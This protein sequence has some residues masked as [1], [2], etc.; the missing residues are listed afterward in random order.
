[1]GM[2]SSGSKYYGSGV[3]LSL[4]D[5]FPTQTY[6]KQKAIFEAVVNN[7]D[8]IDAILN[9]STDNYYSIPLET[10]YKTGEYLG[11]PRAYL[12]KTAFG[13][14]GYLS[15]ELI[16]YLYNELGVAAPDNAAFDFYPDIPV[17]TNGKFI[18]KSESNDDYINSDTAL[19]LLGFTLDGLI[20]AVAENPDIKEVNDVT[21]GVNLSLLTDVKYGQRYMYEFFKKLKGFQIASYEDWKAGNY[22][23]N[24]FS[25]SSGEFKYNIAFNYIREEYKYHVGT[26]GTV[27]SKVE[28]KQLYTTDDGKL[29]GNG[30]KYLNSDEYI[31]TYQDTDTTLRTITISG[32]QHRT[33]I[34]KKDSIDPVTLTDLLTD[35][36]VSENFF[37]PLDRSIL[38]SF[39]SDNARNTLGLQGLT[40]N[41]N[42]LK[43]V[44]VKWYQSS[45]F[46][47]FVS[48]VAI[49]VAF[50]TG[51]LGAALITLATTIVA[52]F[53][54][55]L[56]L[57]I[58]VVTAIYTM[59]TS[60]A[61][62]IKD[63]AILTAQQLFQA[64]MSIVTNLAGLVQKGMNYYFAQEAEDL[65]EDYNTLT[66]QAESAQDE[67]DAALELLGGDRVPFNYT[68]GALINTNESPTDFYSRTIHTG[69]IGTLVYDSLHNLTEIGLALPEADYTFE[70][71]SSYG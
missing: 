51:G 63:A 15:E 47:I 60:L 37:V 11:Y 66:E 25:Y 42:A 43:K 24:Y 28:L 46:K 22:T 3:A 53:S 52:S 59:G 39:L 44:K 70:G 45:I 67:I 54:P 36:E 4:V 68:G 26:Q 5:L 49:V 58:G 18:T 20:T 50:F 9:V 62:V 64:T 29:F 65:L 32:L 56:A 6:Y 57:V 23:V 10:Y 38:K 31:L 48:V 1:M 69:N 2:F 41:I 14:S 16:S 40:M 61:T 27:T 7:T 21:V 35:E 13:G 71:V 19:Q 33:Y 12:S 17:R 34:H 55:E 8:V 30:V